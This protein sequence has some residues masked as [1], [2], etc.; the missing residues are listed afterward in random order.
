M[1]KPK[2]RSAKLAGP[3]VYDT[4]SSG[5]RLRGAQ[6]IARVLGGEILLG[7]VNSSFEKLFRQPSTIVWQTADYQLFS[8][9]LLVVL[10]NLWGRRTVGICYRNNQVSDGKVFRHALRNFLFSIWNALPY[11][12]ALTTCTNNPT[13]PPK[14]FLYDIEMWD[15]SV[16]PLK[17]VP[18]TVIRRSN[19]KTV[20][21]IGSLSELKGINYFVDAAIAASTKSSNLNFVLIGGRK[22]IPEDT[23]RKIEQYNIQF[24]PGPS[25][26]EIFLSYIQQADLLWCCYHPIYDQSSG[27]FGRSVQLGKSTIVRKDSILEKWQKICG[28]GISVT[29]GDNNELIEKLNSWDFDMATNTGFAVYEKATA[30]LKNACARS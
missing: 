27:I 17:Q 8:F 21:C 10:R 9:T 2:R 16:A 20:L 28:S 6:V 25:E 13:S 1:S 7:P 12:T 30:I 15:L 19:M 29:Y 5:H 23:L 14:H 18:S 3:L 22:G 24:I 4:S 26:D 11:S